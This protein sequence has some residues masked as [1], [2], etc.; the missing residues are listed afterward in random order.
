ISRAIVASSAAA[1]MPNFD[2][3][4]FQRIEARISALAS[5]I[6]EVAEDRPT[7]A[8][9]DHLN[10][11]SRRV[12]DLAAQG[13]VPD[14]AVERLARQIAV[15]SEKMDKT[16]TA[17]DADF[18]FQGIEQRFELLTSMIERRQGDAI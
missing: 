18:L 7:V 10:Q 3:E 6:E 13:V 2:P 11:L 12:D 9:I 4:P 14:V 15:I 5:Q 1:Q 17:P 16:S 8:I